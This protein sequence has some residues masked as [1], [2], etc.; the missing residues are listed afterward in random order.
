MKTAWWWPSWIETC[1][2]YR[3][4]NKC[5]YSNIGLYI[6][7]LLCWQPYNSTTFS[8]LFLVPIIISQL[9]NVTV[10]FLAISSLTVNLISSRILYTLLVFSVCHG[11]R[12]CMLLKIPN[13]GVKHIYGHMLRSKEWQI[14]LNMF[15]CMKRKYEKS[16]RWIADDSDILRA[17]IFIEEV[18]LCSKLYR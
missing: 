6:W 13:A 7:R 4:I 5:Q 8:N 1:S 18:I 14:I 3:V 15:K 2:K 10:F 16:I 12:K 9:S 17:V 11:N